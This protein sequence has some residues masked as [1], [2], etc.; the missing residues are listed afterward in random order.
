MLQAGAQQEDRQPER[1]RWWSIS[2]KLTTA[3]LL[4]IVLTLVA[5]SVGLWQVLVIG[6]AIEDALEQQQQLT[7]S[8]ELLAVGHR[9]VAALESMILTEDPLLAS[10]EVAESMGGLSFYMDTLQQTQVQAEMGIAD[11]LAD[12]Q[13]S[14][15]ELRRAVDE[16]DVLARQENW[17]EASFVLEEDLRPANEEMGHFL[18]QLVREAEQNV[19]TTALRVEAIVQRAAVVLVILV[20]L[21]TAIALGWRQF[22]FR[23][24]AESITELREG[25]ARIS[26]GDL[27]H[28]LDVRTGDE[29]EEL[30]GEFNRMASEL[31]GLIVSLEQRVADRT[32]DLEKRS[33][34]L[35]AAAQVAREAAKI[36]EVNQLLEEV[37]NLISQRF[38][39]YHAGIFL[40]DDVGEYAVLRAASSDGGRRMLMQGHKLRVGAVGVVGYAA[41]SGVPRIA[42][43]VGADAE[44]FDNPD[45]PLTR[46]EIALP[47]RVREQV[48]G[49]LDVQSQEPEAFGEQDLALLQTLAD[50]V[51]LA[52][53]NAR[54]LDES[55]RALQELEMLYGRRLREAWQQR[56]AGQKAYRYTRTGVEPAP[57]TPASGLASSQERGQPSIE[58]EEEG[59]RLVAPISLRDQ[60]LGSL[61]FRQ[62]LGQTPWSPEDMAMVEE[63]SA[64][65][66]LALEYARLLEETQRGAARERTIGEVTG[67]MRESLE[68]ETVLRTAAEEMRQALGLDRVVVRLATSDRDEHS[69]QA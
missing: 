36:R 14:Y 62:E 54:L 38:G 59:Q 60:V 49:V 65:I 17:A 7:D 42:M 18:R 33:V 39:F 32:Q 40:V 2:R 3:S 4:M 45:L 44:Y 6:Q 19:E 57:A 10:T 50:Q 41:G 53:E 47:L 56:R 12:M 31:N 21:T 24:L 23:G 5:G 27:E 37:V 43:D 28:E 25:V 35:E 48:I 11:L 63:L 51:A 15:T 67:R 30:A 9:L 34:Q 58:Q 66:G 29:V 16:I 20:V 22:V 52:I 8:L 64:Q 26:R 13:S 69:P 61:V 68:L 1:R 46:S 55:Q